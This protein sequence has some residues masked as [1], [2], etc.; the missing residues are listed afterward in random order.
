[1]LKTRELNYLSTNIIFLVSIMFALLVG[2]GFYGYG[3]DFYEAYYKSNLSWGGVFDRLGYKISTLTIYGTHIGV[4]IVTFILALSSGLL[5]REHIKF[6]RSYSLLFFILLYLIA[7]HTWPIIMSTSNAMRQGLSMSFIFLAL[8]ASSRRN[9]YW[10]LLFSMPAIF[11]HKTGILLVLIIYFATIF[12]TLMANYSY[13]SKPIISFAIG[14]L[15]LTISYF[16]LGIFGFVLD[17]DQGSRI[18]AGDFRLFFVFISFVYISLSFFYRELLESSFNLALYFFSFISL[19]LLLNDLNWQYERL[20]MMMLIPYI[21]SFGAVLNRYSYSIYLIIIFL[22]LVLLTIYT[23][24]YD[25][26]K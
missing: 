20:G 14:L 22:T 15:A 18:I 3:H 6:K 1:M 2:S 12:N 19:S 21:L 4:Q 23:G 26:L 24:M 25:A 7:I 8:I 17:G 10:M 9:Y 16:G 13:K 11:T 5:I